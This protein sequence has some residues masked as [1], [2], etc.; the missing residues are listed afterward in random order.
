MERDIFLIQIYTGAS[1][2]PRTGHWPLRCV[3]QCECKVSIGSLSS[4]DELSCHLVVECWS[5]EWD[6]VLPLWYNLHKVQTRWHND[7]GSGSKRRIQQQQERPTWR[8]MQSERERERERVVY[9]CISLKI[10]CHWCCN[11]VSLFVC[12]TSSFTWLHTLMRFLNILTKCVQGMHHQ[13]ASLPSFLL[14]RKLKGT[15]THTCFHCNS[16]IEN[17][18]LT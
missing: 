17:M 18:R 4:S 2:F 5:F 8:L 1:L 13:P 9:F 7:S 12:F 10:W 15:H 3:G 14:P 16:Q 6:V 11:Y